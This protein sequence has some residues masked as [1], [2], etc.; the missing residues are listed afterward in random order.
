[1]NTVAFPFLTDDEVM[2]VNPPKTSPGAP[3]YMVLVDRGQLMAWGGGVELWS[4]EGKS[5]VAES[6]TQFGE[7]RMYVRVAD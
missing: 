3:P 4:F 5:Y 1:M 6:F 2:G 7:T